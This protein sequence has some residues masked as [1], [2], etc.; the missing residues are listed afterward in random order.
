MQGVGT[1]YH[2]AAVTA[3]AGGAKTVWPMGRFD[4]EAVLELIEKIREAVGKEKWPFEPTGREEKI[5]VRV[6]EV[7]LQKVIEACNIA[8]KH[9]R[10]DRFSEIKKEVVAELTLENRLLKKS[11]LGDGGDDE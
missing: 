2:C 11:M 7:G 1:V 9:P 3:L 6:K 10:Y 5:D 8:E 4:A